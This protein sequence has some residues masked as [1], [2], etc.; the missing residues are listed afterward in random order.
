MLYSSCCCIHR[1]VSGISQLRHNRIMNPS[2]H[3]PPPSVRHSTPSFSDFR[4]W[5]KSNDHHFKLR[6]QVET[7]FVLHSNRASHFLLTKPNSWESDIMFSPSLA[8]SGSPSWELSMTPS[9]FPSEM[10]TELPTFLPVES[11]GL[12]GK[13]DKVID[14]FT[15]MLFV[16][17]I[18]SFIVC[19]IKKFMKKDRYTEHMMATRHSSDDETAVP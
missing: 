4:V 6:F 19:F 8:P 1:F 3:L 5:I 16:A 12:G 17:V 14:A 11:N 2:A 18:G 7:F 13:M 15:A 9:V 10:P